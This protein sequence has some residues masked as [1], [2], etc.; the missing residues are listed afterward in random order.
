MAPH[1]VGLLAAP[2]LERLPETGIR[3]PVV[4]PDQLRQEPA[5]ELVL[6]LRAGLEH[7]QSLAQAVVDALVVAGLEMQAGDRFVR[8][9]VATV[10]RIAAMQPKPADVIAW[11]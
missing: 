10:E 3:H 11:R 8:T 4:A 5:G 9:P 2:G 1:R 6:A 7:A